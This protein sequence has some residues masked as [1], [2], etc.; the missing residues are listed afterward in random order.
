VIQQFGKQDRI[1]R[2]KTMRNNYSHFYTP[3]RPFLLSIIKSI[4]E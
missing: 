2:S 3:K 1:Q 4:G